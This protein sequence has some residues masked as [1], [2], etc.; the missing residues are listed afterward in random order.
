M[1]SVKI[2]TYNIMQKMEDAMTFRG[3]NLLKGTH[4]EYLIADVTRQEL[5]ELY[6]CS[7]I[8]W[9][10][11][12]HIQKI[13]QGNIFATNVF[14]LALAEY[15]CPV[16]MAELKKK[17]GM[18]NCIFQGFMAEK[19]WNPSY[20]Q[21]CKAQEDVNRL[22]KLDVGRGSFYMGRCHMDDRLFGYLNG[23]DNLP[24]F[25][26][27][28]VSC[29][30]P[31]MNTVGICGME[32]VVTQIEN[33]MEQD[34][35]F[36]VEGGDGSGRKTVVS[37]AA[38]NR[39]CPVLMVNLE[40]TGMEN[41]Q[42][43]VFYI[44]RELYLKE[45][46][47]CVHGFS[48]EWLKKQGYTEKRFL[49][50]WNM[51]FLE[52]GFSMC[53]CVGKEFELIQASEIPMVEVVIPEMDRSTRIRLWE[54]FSEK[55]KLTLPAEQLGIKYRLFPGEIKK[56]C[57]LVHTIF[58]D[59]SSVSELEIGKICQKVLPASAAGGRILYPDDKMGF[60]DLKLPKKEKQQLQDICNNVRFSHM[61]LDKWNMESRFSYG[62]AI[63]VLFC[64][65]SGTGKTMAANILAKELGYPLYHVDLSQMIDKYIGETEKHLQQVF[66][67]AQKSN[68]ILF[69]DEAD[70][71]F[72]KRSEVKDSKDKHA[73][74]QVAFILQRIEEYDGIVIL[75]SNLKENI[76]PAFMRRMKYLIY[77]P[78]PDAQVRQ[79]I[80]ESCFPKEMPVENIDFKYLGENF[81]LTGGNIKNIVLTAAFYA[82]GEERAVGMVHIIRAIQNEYQ[83]MGTLLMRE[84][85]GMYGPYLEVW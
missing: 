25:L 23:D 44:R 6:M 56:V 48:K 42:K 36:Y 57:E 33:Q 8:V 50:F 54:F 9:Q 39:N 32:N 72:G 83:K 35:C 43:Y 3:C 16:F 64:G 62:K 41:L 66:E 28:F 21:L 59:E 51:E 53:F 71:V 78:R 5:E 80:W 4:L 22:L 27:E 7:D 15:M 45:A 61:V 20:E 31:E 1:Q 75:A 11:Y 34:T 58:G 68:T 29:I 19:N 77:F 17:S 37:Q 12:E 40:Y 18:E 13:L 47:L 2:I 69:F 49:H 38:K 60:E 67:Q 79:E 55:Y 73:N 81:E 30:M 24:S 46:F 14:D 76:D 85:L 65:A 82:A 10:R 84:E 63:S 52:K 70:A 26:Q 74:T